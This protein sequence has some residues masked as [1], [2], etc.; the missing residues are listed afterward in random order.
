MR[1]ILITLGMLLPA[2]GAMMMIRAGES[3]PVPGALL[4]VASSILIAGGAL[5]DRL[6]RAK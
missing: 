6:D 5:L 4:I 1:Y 2:L 3:G